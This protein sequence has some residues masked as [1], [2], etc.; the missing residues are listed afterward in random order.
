MLVTPTSFTSFAPLQKETPIV[1]GKMVALQ[2][3]D[4]VT[5]SYRLSGSGAREQPKGHTADAAERHAAFGAGMSGVGGGP[6]TG[7]NGT[8]DETVL[9]RQN[10]ALAQQVDAL[11]M[12]NQEAWEQYRSAS[13][14]NSRSTPVLLSGTED[15][16]EAHLKGERVAQML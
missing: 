9:R 7:K 5:D 6:T 10:A 16:G 8:L 3:Y 4:P 13:H 15:A 2:R 11:K 12:S 14:F 1:S